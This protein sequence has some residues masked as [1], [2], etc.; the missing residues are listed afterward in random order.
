METVDYAFVFFLVFLQLDP[1]EVSQS[2]SITIVDNAI[3][4][5]HVGI[6]VRRRGN[7][8]DAVNQGS[9][10]LFEQVQIVEYF[11]REQIAAEKHYIKRQYTLFVSC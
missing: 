4:S 2:V 1:I 11:H 9:V 10:L 6:D 5:L 3:F 7:H 8:L